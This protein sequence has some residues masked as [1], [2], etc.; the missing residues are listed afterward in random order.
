MELW[1]ALFGNIDAKLSLTIWTWCRTNHI[2]CWGENMQR[3]ILHYFCDATFSYIFRFSAFLFNW[4]LCSFCL[5]FPFLSFSSLCDLAFVCSLW[6]PFLNHFSGFSFPH[7]NEIL[8]CFKLKRY[9]WVYLCVKFMK[10]HNFIFIWKF[11]RAIKKI[12][13]LFI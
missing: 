7:L 4:I 5:C 8:L 3:S 6:F 12:R 2:M 9:V 1:R 13:F 10:A 11:L